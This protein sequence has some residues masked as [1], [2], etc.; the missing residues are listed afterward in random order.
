MHV[1]PKIYATIMVMRQLLCNELRSHR[2]LLSI[3]D[4]RVLLAL[5]QE[6]PNGRPPP[7]ALSHGGPDHRVVHLPPRGA[8]RVQKLLTQ[9]PLKLGTL[10][11]IKSGTQ[12]ELAQLV[13][14]NFGSAVLL[15]HCKH[16]HLI[17]AVLDIH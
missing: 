7:A 2:L 11:A 9:L 15:L 12:A 13:S 3:E 14:R 4:H 16:H 10:A 17:A 8:H 1:R 5:V 6:D